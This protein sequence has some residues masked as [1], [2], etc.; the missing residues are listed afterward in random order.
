MIISTS[1][2]NSIE[3]SGLDICAT[4]TVSKIGINGLRETGLSLRCEGA[5]KKGSII[6]NDSVKTVGLGMSGLTETKS[7]IGINDLGII[8]SSLYCEGVMKKGSKVDNN[9]IETTSLKMSGLGEIGS[10]LRHD[11][12]L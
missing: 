4:E 5:I 8:G 6:D 12:H 11:G 1:D 7:I 10:S 9:S 3:I 2:E